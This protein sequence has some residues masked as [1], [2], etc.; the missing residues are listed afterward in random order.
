MKWSGLPFLN[1]LRDRDA[2]RQDAD[3]DHA[4]MGTAFGL[5]ASF[6]PVEAAPALGATDAE[7]QPWEARLIRRSGL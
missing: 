6:G 1:A 4:D 3:D 2:T 7:A 5:D